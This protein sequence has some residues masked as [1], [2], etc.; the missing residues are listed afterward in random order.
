MSAGFDM[1]PRREGK[2]VAAS[3]GVVIGR[4]RRIAAGRMRIPRREVIPE[5][6]G[7]EVSRLLRAIEAAVHEIDVERQHLMERRKDESLTILDA[8]RM[9]L[10]DP[11]LVSNARQRIMD[12]CINAEWAL[13]QEMDA[14]M[15]VFD[16][17]ED[18]YL[19]QRREDIEQ[20]GNRILRHL[21]QDPNGH[22]DVADEPLIYVSEDFSPPDVVALWRKGVAGLVAEQ[23]GADAHNIIVARGIS[24]PA[25]IGATGILENIEDDDV[26]ILDAEQR[27][28]VL[29]PDEEE[30]AAYTRFMQAVRLVRD[31]LQSFACKPSLSADGHPMKLMANIEFPEELE[32]ADAIGI[33]GIGLYRTEFM[34]MESDEPP[35]EEEQYRQYARVA[36]SMPD[37]PVTMRLLDIGGD[38]MGLYQG[39]L[40]REFGGANP[41]MGLRGIRLLLERPAWLHTQLRA[42]IRANGHRNVR[43]LVPMVCHVDEMLAVRSTI[44]DIA[45]RLGMPAPELGAMIEVPAAVMIADELA[46]V[47]DFFS[48]GTN[49][50][51]QYTLAADRTDEDVAAFYG[52]PHVAIERLIAMTVA[53]AR[54]AG[55]DVS[56]CGELAA[57]E[58]WT[59]RFLR[60]DIDA[61]SMTLNRVLAIRRQLSRSTYRPA[62]TPDAVEESSS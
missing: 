54:R 55:I 59:E 6:L 50:L 46:A 56:V 36:G 10:Q 23:G 60:M 21:M 8:H 12:A 35:T 43:V 15:Q 34:F 26:L 13:R 14:V 1:R 4:V 31:G 24:L 28:W 18:E 61:L 42:M 62:K 40:G 30:A 51:T 20:A 44:K 27:R 53:A 33:D 39:I 11:E 37:R 2:A 29:N 41:A 7:H 52:R 19:R 45:G 16:A 32:L 22:E 25:L 5:R 49:D 17:V 3:S 9:L 38:K 47:S 58:T 48:I 57:D